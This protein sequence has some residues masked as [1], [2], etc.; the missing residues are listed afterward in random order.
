MDSK[1]RVRDL[2][3]KTSE[4]IY[5]STELTEILASMPAPNGGKYEIDMEELKDM[6]LFL[7]HISNDELSAT[8]EHVKSIINK[9]PKIIGMTKD[10]ILQE[11]VSA[12]LS[13][14]LNVDAIHLEVI[15]SNQIREGLD[16]D[17][18][19]QMPHWEFDYAEYA[20]VNLDTALKNHPSI[21]TTLEY[22]KVAKTLYNPLSYRKS[23]PSQMDL[24]FMNQPQEFMTAVETVKSENKEPIRGIIYDTEE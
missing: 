18:I 15:L 16:D 2:Y 11:F 23:S 20:L 1:G 17:K 3:S 21:T 10:K 4:N 19:L 5:L 14:G 7:I 13:G 12:V 9:Y 22:Q 24:F 8:L 6:N